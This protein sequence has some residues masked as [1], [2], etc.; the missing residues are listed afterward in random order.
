M[1]RATSLLLEGLGMMM[2]H[3]GRKRLRCSSSTRIET[4]RMFLVLTL[5]FEDT[6]R[7]CFNLSIMHLPYLTLASIFKEDGTRINHCAFSLQQCPSDE[8]FDHTDRALSF[9]EIVYRSCYWME[10]YP[11]P[12]CPIQSRLDFMVVLRFVPLCHDAIFR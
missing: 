12:H 1:D 2:N 11:N 8:V 10:M 9:K 3:G 5:A 6:P 4:F 7:K